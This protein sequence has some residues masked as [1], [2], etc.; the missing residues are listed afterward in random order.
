MAA[1]FTTETNNHS[2]ASFCFLGH[3][4]ICLLVVQM[5]NRFANPLHYMVLLKLSL[6]IYFLGKQIHTYDLNIKYG[7]KLFASQFIWCP[8]FQFK[9]QLQPKFVCKVKITYESNFT[10]C[11]KFA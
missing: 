2:Q 1:D 11:R 3:M 8:P 6:N 5:H 9:L 10:K 4:R 7:M